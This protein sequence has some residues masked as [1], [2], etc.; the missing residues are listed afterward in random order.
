M[1]SFGSSRSAMANGGVRRRSEVAAEVSSVRC[2]DIIESHSCTNCNRA[3]AGAVDGV[4][5]MIIMDENAY[6]TGFKST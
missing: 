6:V 5:M 4:T 3:L 1:V 2:H